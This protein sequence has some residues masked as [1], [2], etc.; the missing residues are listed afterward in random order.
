MTRLC[1]SDVL[2]IISEGKDYDILI[3]Q[4]LGLELPAL[5]ARVGC[6][7]EETLKRRLKDRRA[8]VISISSGGG[9]VEGFA[10][11]VAN[12]VNR[13]GL[14]AKVM[15]EAD[16]AGFAEAR[17]WGAEILLYAD[18]DHFVAQDL[19]GGFTADNNPGTSL[20]YAA[21][22]EAMAGGLKGREL[23]L[24]GLGIIGRGA[25]SRLLEM[26]A[27]PL[28]Y[29]LDTEAANQ[30]L[31]TGA[32]LLNGPEDLKRALSRTNLIYEATPVAEA[33]A[34]ALWPLHPVVAAPGVP[35]SWPRA[36]LKPGE[37][38]R[39]W[40]DPLQ[41]GVAGMLGLLAAHI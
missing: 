15:G 24:L 29:D 36:W 12:I 9:V 25:V 39:L 32:E 37:R 31:E 30:A 10:R 35:L 19:V 1:A 22:L 5:A 14:Q 33:L 17:Q 7:E 13:L 18:D 20:V 26:G 27:T 21:A 11:S 6:L 8:A 2:P 40:H 16:E 23:V 34:E 38:G 4:A 41:S 28:L 3:K